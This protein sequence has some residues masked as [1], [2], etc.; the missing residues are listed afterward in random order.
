MKNRNRLFALLM[1]VIM[2]FTYM[3]AITFAESEESDGGQ[4][5]TET[6]GEVVEEPV[7]EEKLE[8]YRGQVLDDSQ[9]KSFTWKGADLAYYPLQDGSDYAIV[10]FDELGNEAVVTFKDGT[11]HTL[12]YKK[13][14]YKD[15]NGETCTAESWLDKDTNELA[16]FGCLSGGK[17]VIDVY[18]GSSIIAKITDVAA[19]PYPTA[20]SFPDNMITRSQSRDEDGDYRYFYDE[21]G[22]TFTVTYSD[23]KKVKKFESVEVKR[24]NYDGEEYTD[25]AYFI[26]G[27]TNKEEAYLEIDYEKSDA[28]KVTLT[29]Q[30]PETYYHMTASPKVA[31]VHLPVSA[32]FVSANGGPSAMVGSTTIE[33]SCYYGEGNKF[34]VRYD[35]G[36]SEDYIYTKYTE[37]GENLEAFCLDGNKNNTH[38]NVQLIDLSSGLKRGENSITGK[39]SLWK[40]GYDNAVTASYTTTFNCTKH[41]SYVDSVAFPY[42]GKNIPGK[43][44]KKKIKVIGANDNGKFVTIPANGYTAT[45]AAG[46][47]IGDHE[48]TVRFTGEY[49]TKY[50]SEIRGAYTICPKT[51]TLSSVKAGKKKSGKFTAKWKAAK[52]ASGYA[53]EYGTNKSFKT[54]D[55]W[56]WIDLG[57]RKSY[58]VS[59]LKARKTY[60]VRVWA[61][62]TVTVRNPDGTIGTDY[63]FSNE[64]K[65]KKVKI[66]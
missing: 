45:Y 17:G 65:V 23:G 13:Y 32:T 41:K 33:E 28:D 4:Q 62:K 10:G 52:G 57:N 31:I 22:M 35:N 16:A 8:A 18:Y 42:T 53:L 5:V 58:T 21:P 50:G 1:S 43:T 47:E 11:T 15:E 9:I 48:V 37:N 20:I 40:M 44:L 59:N 12:I 14:Q 26:D 34:T 49:A 2:V 63:I 64:G 39:V 30:D 61:Y 19:L 7:V 66:K 56:D 38:L 46:K 24:K 60:Y 51:P 3:P 27:D 25:S 29:Y 6:A 36:K 55:D 54:N